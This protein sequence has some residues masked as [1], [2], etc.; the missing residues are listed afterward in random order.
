MGFR[1]NYHQSSIYSTIKMTIVLMIIWITRVSAQLANHLLTKGLT[2]ILVNE[3]DGA[4]KAIN[5]QEGLV[6]S[7]L[8]GKQ[9]L[10]LKRIKSLFQIMQTMRVLS[11]TL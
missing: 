11:I 7:K 9:G 5:Q 4:R 1:L 3:W 2:Q 10:T 8:L 6:I